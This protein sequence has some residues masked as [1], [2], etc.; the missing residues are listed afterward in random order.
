[1]Q[2]FPRS[3]VKDYLSEEIIDGYTPRV[4]E[5]CKLEQNTVALLLYLRNNTESLLLTQ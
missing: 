1:M 5:K 2:V 4:S 3:G